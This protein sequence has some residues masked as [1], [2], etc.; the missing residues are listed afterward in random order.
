[1]FGIHKILSSRHKFT[2]VIDSIEI[3]LLFFQDGINPNAKK[4]FTF[5]V[6]R[7]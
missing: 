7:G 1:M 5:E 2:S 3:D 4:G 6:K